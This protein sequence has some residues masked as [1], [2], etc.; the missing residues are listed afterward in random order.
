MPKVKILIVEDE[1][2]IA[3]DIAFQLEDMGYEVVEMATSYDEA[4]AA[5]KEHSPSLVLLD[6]EILGDKDGVDVAMYI[7]ENT[8][9]PFLF[10]TSNADFST[11]ARAKST[12]PN[13]YLM[14]PLKKND[15]FT[16]VEMALANNNAVQAT[17]KSG[18]DDTIFVQQEDGLTKI[19]QSAILWLKAGGNYTEVHT[20][21]ERLLVRGN[22]KDTHSRLNDNFYRVQKSYV[23][24]LKAI[25]KIHHAYVMIN[26]TEIPVGHKFREGLLARINKL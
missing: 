5:I 26:E 3:Q 15:I 1:L 10:L 9:L 21:T 23:V 11:V 13:G 7:R 24:N 25:D 19:S 4:V 12:R 16:S 8:G 17:A 22:I 18:D 2:I 20:A 14:K 6:I